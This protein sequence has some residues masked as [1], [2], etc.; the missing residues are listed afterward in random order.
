MGG[1]IPKPAQAGI[2]MY[3]FTTRSE[4]SFRLFFLYVFHNDL[5][6]YKYIYIQ[7]K[8]SFIDKKIVYIT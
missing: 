4:Y 2:A 5:Y 3:S 7:F 8:D 6:I 1:L